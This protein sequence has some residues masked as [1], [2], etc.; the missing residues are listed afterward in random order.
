MSS[1]YRGQTGSFGLAAG[2]F[3][4]SELYNMGHLAYYGFRPGQENP[5]S[6]PVLR[7]RHK[8]IKREKVMFE[9]GRPQNSVGTKSIL[10]TFYKR[11]RKDREVKNAFRLYRP[12]RI[13]QW[14]YNTYQLETGGHTVPVNL[15]NQVSG[16]LSTNRVNAALNATFCFLNSGSNWGAGPSNRTMGLSDPGIIN[17]VITRSLIKQAC[18]PTNGPMDVTT[19]PTVLTDDNFRY[20]LGPT[21]HHVMLENMAPYMT[22]LEVYVLQTK[23]DNIMNP[24]AVIEAASAL[25][26]MEGSTGFFPKETIENYATKPTHFRNFNEKFR[27]VSKKSYRLAAGTGLEL[28]VRTSGWRKITGVMLSNHTNLMP[29]TSFFIYLRAK[30]PSG[31]VKPL[32]EIDGGICDIPVKL[33]YRIKEHISVLP[34]PFDLE[35]KSRIRTDLGDF[36]S[37]ANVQFFNT[38][39]GNPT[40]LSAA[41]ALAS[42]MMGV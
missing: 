13:A 4:V 10:H 39:S 33:G 40:N 16:T 28:I 2:V 19:A 5:D 17:G 7:S 24:L 15:T 32:G 11:N 31:W 27:V 8:F 23:Y 30:G 20:L 6:Y 35:K 29:D 26:D 3:A 41:T 21:S 34:C 1:D 14:T 37:L 18:G 42:S 22:D 12:V 36:I 38:A 25:E 9:V